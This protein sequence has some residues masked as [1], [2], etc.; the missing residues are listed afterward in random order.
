MWFE[1]STEH[2]TTPPP[3]IPLNHHHLG[4]VVLL[5]I[6]DLYQFGLAMDFVLSRRNTALFSSPQPRQMTV[7]GRFT[8]APSLACKLLELSFELCVGDW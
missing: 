7:A 5:D 8:A 4:C 2:T 1:D 6:R 3:T